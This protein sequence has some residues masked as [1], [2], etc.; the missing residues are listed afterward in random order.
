MLRNSWIKSITV[1]E[2]LL[3]LTHSGAS[4]PDLSNQ[5][6]NYTFVSLEVELSLFPHSPPPNSYIATIL[7]VSRI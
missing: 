5:I 3:A 7:S 1:S 6:V 2:S 4:E